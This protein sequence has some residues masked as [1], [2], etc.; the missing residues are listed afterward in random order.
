MFEPLKAVWAWILR[1]GEIIMFKRK[2][3]YF[4]LFM[5][6]IKTTMSIYFVAFVF[7]YFGLGLIG[8]N[9]PITLNFLTTLQI[10]AAC[11][12]IGFG[13]GVIVSRNNVSLPRLL[14]WAVWSLLVT[15]GFSTAFQ[16]FREF[17]LWYS[18][19]FYCMITVS[20]IFMYLAFQW[21]LQR[22]TKK[23]NEALSE[24]KGRGGKPDG[25]N[26]D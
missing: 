26:S 1:R 21:H 3:Q 11:L 5:Y 7:F 13:Q 25:S 8:T 18:I 4:Y 6:D 15:V 14:I 2:W 12:L 23:L 10:M 19:V 17:P 24:Y 20:F 9:K 22:E 16:W